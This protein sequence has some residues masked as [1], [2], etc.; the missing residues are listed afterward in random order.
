MCACNLIIIGS[1]NGLSRGRRHAIIQTNSGILLIRI[2]GTNFSETL[3]EIYTFSSKS[4]HL[5]MSSAK[6]R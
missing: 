6:W 3:S 4:M 1:D 5:K 2:I